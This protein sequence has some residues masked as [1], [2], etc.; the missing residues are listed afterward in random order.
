M[1]HISKYGKTECEV[2]SPSTTKYEIL[3]KKVINK[4]D[5]LVKKKKLSNISARNKEKEV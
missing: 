4:Y 3:D 2:L 5:Y 1:Q